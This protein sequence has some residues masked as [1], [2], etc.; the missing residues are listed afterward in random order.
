ME[1]C[2]SSHQLFHMNSSCGY[3]VDSVFI[4]V[5]LPPSG[6]TLEQQSDRFTQEVEGHSQ[7][8]KRQESQGIETPVV[9]A[10]FFRYFNY[11]IL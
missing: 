1:T 7:E 8:P 5:T 10:L 3:D 9:R 6:K 11:F 2:L 4:A